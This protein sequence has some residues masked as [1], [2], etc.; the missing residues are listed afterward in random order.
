MMEMS[1]E[2][3]NHIQCWVA[4]GKVYMIISLENSTFNASSK[5]PGVVDVSQARWH[6]SQS[7]IFGDRGGGRRVH[8]WK[9]TGKPLTGQK[10]K[11]DSFF[12]GAR[13]Y[14]L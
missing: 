6:I 3:L 5:L 12:K 14:V 10:Y 1:Q 13:V 9:S 4:A 8:I 2:S 7:T 11:F